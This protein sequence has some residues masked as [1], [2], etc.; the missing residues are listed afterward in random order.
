MHRNIVSWSMVHRLGLTPDDPAW[1]NAQT[2]A[3]RRRDER[4]S[5]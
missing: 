2:N 1:K 4:R 3:G 5:R